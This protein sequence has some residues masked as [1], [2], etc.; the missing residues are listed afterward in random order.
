MPSSDVRLGKTSARNARGKTFQKFVFKFF[1]G[2]LFRGSY[3]L[4]LV[5]GCKSRENFPLYG[6]RVS[7][8]HVYTVRGVKLWGEI[9]SEKLGTR[10]PQMFSPRRANEACLVAC[11]I[12]FSE[13]IGR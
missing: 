11:F 2:F 5:V 13:E 7:Q 9:D 3:F 1:C 6:S 12:Q 8:I 4:I 10:L